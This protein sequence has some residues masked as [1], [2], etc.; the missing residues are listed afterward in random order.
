MTSSSQLV[1]T[2]LWGACLELLTM[3]AEG[4]DARSRVRS[5]VKSEM[6]ADA[7]DYRRRTTATAKRQLK[8]ARRS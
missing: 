1:L 4:Q 5:V 2:F 8:R 7:N 3:R 6:A